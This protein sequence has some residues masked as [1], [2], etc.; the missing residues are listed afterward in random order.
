MKIIS[1]PQGSTEWLDLRRSKITGTDSSILTGS[2]V[3]KTKLTL[4]EQKLQLIPPDE[5]TPRMQRGSELEYPARLLLQESLGMEF[6]PIVAISDEYPY[7]MASLDGISDCKRFMCEIK[8]PGLKNHEASIEGI[9]AEY[10]IDQINHCLLVT[11]CEKCF[12]CSYFPG[13]EREIAIIEVYPDGEKQAEIIEKGY[14]FY[15]DLQTMNP[16]EEWKFK[17]KER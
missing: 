2:N 17:P 16:P 15:K 12:F 5:C 13:H 1:V 6:T 4:W 8:C 3:F 7:L 11:G 10:Y 14:Q 9:I